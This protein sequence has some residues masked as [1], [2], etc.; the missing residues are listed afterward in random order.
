MPEFTCATCGTS[1]TLAESILE[2]YPGWTPRYCREHSKKGRGKSGGGSKAKKT[3]SGASQ[4]RAGG[5][6]HEENLRLEEVLAKYT[7]GPQTGLFTDG[8]CSPNP[9]PGGWGM[10][11]VVDGEIIAQERG[12][13]ADT[14]NNRME[15]SAI[16]AAF[17]V[18]DDDDEAT[19]Y[20]DSQ[21]CI[22]TLNQWA[23]GW[24]KNGW[25]KKTGPVKNLDLVKKAYALKKAH[26][27]VK[28][29]YIA[30]HSG[31]RWN[32]YADSLATAYSRDQL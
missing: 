27:R 10:V 23:A 15:M 17:E 32:E 13:E 18:L 16:I 28:V 29:E 7:D 19:I 21:L 14:T 9:G 31:Y 26:P 2:K 25:K 3:S 4:K 24:E 12:H 6:R 20:S 8:A 11:H 5:S 30:A 1:F 22:N